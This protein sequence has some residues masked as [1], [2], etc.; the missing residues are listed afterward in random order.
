M[1]L[2][3]SFGL[4]VVSERLLLEID[5]ESDVGDATK[6][7]GR[8]ARRIDERH[9]MLRA[10]YL[11]VVNR[12]VLEKRKQVDFVLIM[13]ADQVVV[14]LTGNGENGR[15]VELRVVQPVEQVNRARTRGGEANAEPPRVFCVSARHE[16][17]GL[18]VA[19]LDERHPVLPRAQRF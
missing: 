16:S 3:V 17:S 6:G 15:T 10:H 12:D 7:E 18:F 4:F 8:P 2:Y 9:D 1:S 5:G 19:D 13:R 14:G 11:L